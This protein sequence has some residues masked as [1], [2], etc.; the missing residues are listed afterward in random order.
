MDMA[1]RTRRPA[2]LLASALA[3]VS[4]G[5]MAPA[6]ALA[7]N[8]AA[9]GGASAFDSLL[10]APVLAPG[11]LERAVTARNP[12]LA[13]ARAAF[14]E[15]RARADRTGALMNPMVDVMV[16]PRALG[17]EMMDA[18][19]YV[20]GFSQLF[21]LFG[22]RGLERKAAR[23]EERAMGEDFRATRLDLLREARRLYYEYFLVERGLEVNHELKGL[24]DQFR[25]VAV[26]KYAAGVVGQQDALQAEVELAMLDHEAIVLGRER[27][28]VRASLNALLHRNPDENLPAPTD[29]LPAA[30]EGEESTTAAD[31]SLARPDVRR[32]EA[33]RD[34]RA[35]EL[36][37]AQRRRLP[38]FT[39]LA[40]YDGMEA[41]HEMRPMVGAALSLPIWFGRLGASER[42]A[43][44]GLERKEQDR[45]AAIDRA[46]FEIEEARARVQET[47][48]EIH[49][50]ETGV[51]PATER[52]LTS[53]R[54]AYEANRS[55]F[56]ALLNAE[57]D[58]ARARLGWNRARAEYRMALADWERA[59]ASD[60]APPKEETR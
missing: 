14:D 51:L 56:L 25:S 48:H 46:R 20:V 22:E 28:I 35:A 49:V 39:F 11:L 19:G 57:R 18:P 21:P 33:E 34:A 54:S 12:T 40:R 44:A 58:L 50:I 16:A 2:L 37:L 13:A 26:Q 15:S 4:L 41:E 52:A 27:R 23:A 24:L 9:G 55:D 45:L 31:A 59:I 60:G 30:R 53:I 47:R 17:N 29:S 7:Q 43:R 8:T 1:P 38:E 10:V 3:W 6:A 32:A 36:S 42:E 5:L